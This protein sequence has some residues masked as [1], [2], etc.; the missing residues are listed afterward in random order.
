MRYLESNRV[1]MIPNCPDQLG[2]FMRGAG[3][4]QG[5]RASHGP[6]AQFLPVL[7][8]ILVLLADT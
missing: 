7:P 8:K 3:F 5:I 6:I 1:S 4:W 2:F